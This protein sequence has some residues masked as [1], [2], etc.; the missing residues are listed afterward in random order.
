[1]PSVTCLSSKLKLELLNILLESR[2]GDLREENLNR[3]GKGHF[4]VSGRGHE[5]LAALSIQ[6]EPDD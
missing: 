6:L 4:H 3:Q 1:M 2:H 5:A